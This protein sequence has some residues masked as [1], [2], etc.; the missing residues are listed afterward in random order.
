VTTQ[1]SETYSRAYDLL[2]SGKPYSREV[3][4][5]NDLFQKFGNTGSLP[6]S[7]LDLGCG[8]GKHLSEFPSSTRKFGVDQSNG[9]LAEATSLGLQNFDC[10]NGNICTIRLG[11]TF[12]VVYSLFHVISYQT[13]DLDL[14]NFFSTIR[15]HL[16]VE[17]IGVVDFWHRAPWD[18]DPPLTRV[19]RKSDENTEVVRIST[20]KFDLM[21]GRV[22]INMDL[23]VKESSKADFAHLV[24]HHV[25]RAYTLLELSQA[26]RL[27]GLSVLATGKWMEADTALSATDWYGWLVCNLLEA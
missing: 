16:K 17:G 19:T 25:M 11:E 10:V 7:A 1:F 13:T 12:D 9:M 14:I 8:S 27:A 6:S 26:A 5:L 20:P 18:I 22:E 3:E 21:T 15:E 23:F 4:F 2:N 24:E